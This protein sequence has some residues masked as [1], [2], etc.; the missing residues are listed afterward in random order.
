MTLAEYHAHPALSRT[1]LWRLHESPQKFKYAEEHP[2]EPTQAFKIGA[3]FH[4]MALEPETFDDEFKV[5][6]GYD[7][8]TKEGKQLY[9]EFIENLGNKTS[10]TYDEAETVIGM[11]KSLKANPTAKK[12]IENGQKEKS[13]FWTDEATGIELKCR[14]DIYV[15]DGVNVIVDLKSVTSGDPKQFPRTIYSLGYDVQAAMYIA[16][17]QN[18]KP[19]D[20]E[21]MF[22]A[23]EKTPPYSVT[24]MRLEQSWIDYGKMRYRE[25]LKLYKTCCDLERWYGYNGADNEIIDLSLPTWVE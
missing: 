8:R 7:R 5:Y 6:P 20:Y 1:R 21:F 4:K 12:L 16:G 3:A 22:I 17:M 2:E 24:L 9:A 11:V 19:G 13:F 14:P 18:I 10:L 23:V 15:V 25:L